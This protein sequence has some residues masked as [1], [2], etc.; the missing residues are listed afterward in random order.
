M[1]NVVGGDLMKLFKRENY[2]IKIRGFYHANDIIKV[3]TGIRRWSKSSLMQI[4]ADEIIES[5][6][7]QENIIYIN[8]DKKGILILNKHQN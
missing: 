6:V 2:L 3:I 4:I 1:Y 8:L 7:N 5:G